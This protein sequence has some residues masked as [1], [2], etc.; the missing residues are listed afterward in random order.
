MFQDT[1]FQ[2]TFS[3]SR[4]CIN[5]IMNRM[6][7]FCMS[8]FVV[9]KYAGDYGSRRLPGVCMADGISA[10]WMEQEERI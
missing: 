2:D 7:S 3:D 5:E 1:L 6:C 10:R 4:I 8:Y 9:W